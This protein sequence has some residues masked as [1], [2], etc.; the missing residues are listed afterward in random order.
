MLIQETKTQ[1]FIDRKNLHNKLDVLTQLKFSGR[2]SIS[3]SMRHENHQFAYKCKQ[4]KNVCKINSTLFC[5]NSV[6]VKPNEM[7][8]PVNFHHIQDT[9]KL[10]GV[11][12]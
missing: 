4:L 9:E 3:K 5:N 6:N 1:H 10:L 7:S 2:L 11:T 8:Q 12:N